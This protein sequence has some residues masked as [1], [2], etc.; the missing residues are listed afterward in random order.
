MR[1]FIHPQ[2]AKLFRKKLAAYPWHQDF[3]ATPTSS[4]RSLIVW[5]PRT[6]DPPFGVKTTLDATMAIRFAT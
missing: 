5:N 4:H 1:F 2:S 3:W 6:S